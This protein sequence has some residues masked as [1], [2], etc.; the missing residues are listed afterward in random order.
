MGTYVGI[1]AVYYVYLTLSDTWRTLHAALVKP[2]VG[3]R[4]VQVTDVFCILVTRAN[5]QR[6]TVVCGSALAVGPW[7]KEIT[8]ATPCDADIVR[9]SLD[10][11]TA[12]NSVD[13]VTMVNPYVLAGY[14]LHVVG[15][16][17][18]ESSC[19]LHHDIADDE[20][21]ALLEIEYARLILNRGVNAIIET[22]ARF[23]V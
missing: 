15:R 5:E 21:L 3:Y 6:E 19:T 11:K 20:V 22:C 17:V 7:W 9:A 1:V 13:E 12:V 4:G 23:A 16:T 18:V 14:E 8:E 10:V 2:A